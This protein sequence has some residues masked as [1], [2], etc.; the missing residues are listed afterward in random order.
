MSS[1]LHVAP[2][3]T[4]DERPT[5]IRWLIFGLACGTSWFLYLHR[6]TWNFVA[7]KLKE[8]YGWSDQQA[9]AVYTFFNITYG[10]GQI[11][12][13]ILCDFLGPHVFLVSII[14]LWSVALPLHGL[15]ASRS[16]LEAVR[17]LFGA[18][19]A[20]TFP[21]LA[22]VSRTWFPPS[23]RTS[24]QA[25][26]ATFSGRGG[27]AM[28]SI[29]M[30]SLLMGELQL[31]WRNSLWVMGGAGLI[32]AV[33]FAI[34]FRASPEQDTRVNTA[35]LQHIREGDLTSPTSSER[36]FL[37]WSH[38][39]T[40]MS[41]WFLL[42]QQMLVAGV[43]TIFS[44]YMGEFFMSKGANLKSA[45][46]LVSLPLLG[47]AIG[48]TFAGFLN[49]AL[50]RGDRRQMLK[51]CTLMG[52]VLGGIVTV[53]LSGGLSSG[54][55]ASYWRWWSDILFNLIR[56]S[57]AG[58]VIGGL[59]GAFCSVLL[60]PLA[61]SRRWGRSVMGCIGAS[62]ASLMFVC[63]SSQSS[64]MAAGAAF[65]TL[66][67]FS[68]M[69]QPTQWGASTDLGGRFSAT[70][71]AIVN[72]A[73]NVGGIII[74]NV[75][76]YLNDANTHVEIVNGVSRR[77]INFTP[78]LLTAAVMYAIAAMCWLMTNSTKSLDRAAGESSDETQRR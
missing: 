27:G 26:I 19:Q 63:V 21:I 70:V 14:C 69:Q 47:G 34:F 44:S 77:Q 36:Q 38:A 52:L 76:G 41:L 55:H 13:G 43:D 64:L 67:F 51:I 18:A 49:D 6:Y 35:E 72:T 62:G 60:M 25:C 42:C 56:Q 10:L 12:S 65:F 24:V 9:Q 7:P 54:A 61:G 39:L 16:A 31:S 50:L 2:A 15:A 1:P 28:A 37:S 4:P 74:P 53:L 66:K 40:S 30:A 22:K 32:F 46:W 75:F 8:E 5:N 23:Y 17:L 29:I 59:G 48:G 57:A 33:L 11:P 73:G 71:F 45:G 78:L 68:D 20:G 3:A 58:C